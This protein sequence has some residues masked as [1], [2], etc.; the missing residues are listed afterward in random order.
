[1]LGSFCLAAALLLGGAGIG[2][3]AA[4]Q[5]AAAM[6]RQ[7]LPH[8]LRRLARAD[9]VRLAGAAELAVAV[10]VVLTGNRLT[11]VLLAAAYLAFLTLSARLAAAKAT[12]SCGCFGRVDSPVG[13][14]HLVLN[15]AA[16]AAAVAAAFR[17]PGAW[18]GLLD[19]AV[20]PGVVGVGQA[21]LLAALGYLA[22]TALPALTAERRRATS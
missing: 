9:L 11:L 13:A 21:A 19:G 17:P 16:G 22:I 20:L 15:L 8:R 14:G 1:V 3:L 18:G 12:G 6:L 4:P 7:G 2:K 10:A 5:P